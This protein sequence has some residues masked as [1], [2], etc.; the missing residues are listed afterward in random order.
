MNRNTLTLVAVWIAILLLSGTMLYGFGLQALQGN[1]VGLF[2]IVFATIL[3]VV[4]RRHVHG[5]IARQLKQ[6]ET[7]EPLVAYY[8]RTLVRNITIPNGD[9]LFAH[10]AALAQVFYAEYPAARA[11]LASVNWTGRMP[12]MQACHQSVEAL[13]CYFDTR[14]YERGLNL[15][16]GA[17]K[18]GQIASVLPGAKT[19][20]AA[21]ESYVEIG[22]ILCNRVTPQ[23]LESL[24]GKVG[25]VPT[26]N[27]ILIAWGL[28]VGYTK[29]GNAAQAEAMRIYLRKTAPHCKALTSDLA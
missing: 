18:L 26:M 17:V 16:Q 25:K 15:A 20:A 8:H 27:K 21:Y 5:R 4:I 3:T 11:T 23:T 9:A 14:D 6:S 12:L 28:A 10:A 2:S 13:L 29:V 19:S 24:R 1:Y 22:E 7:A